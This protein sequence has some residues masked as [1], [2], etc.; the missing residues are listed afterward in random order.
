MGLCSS[1]E[2]FEDRFISNV[3]PVRSMIGK[4]KVGDEEAKLIFKAFERVDKGKCTPWQR[5]LC[6][7]VYLFLLH[8]LTFLTLY[9]LASQR[10]I[11][12]N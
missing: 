6:G 3:R 9:V 12:G 11:R 10:Q 7:P 4:L 5:R 1:S 8:P 2:G